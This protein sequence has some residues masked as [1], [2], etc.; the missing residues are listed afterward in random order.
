MNRPSIAF[1]NWFNVTFSTVNLHCIYPT[2]QP[3]MAI[4]TPKYRL[5]S[6]LCSEVSEKGQRLRSKVQYVLQEQSVLDS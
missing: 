2:S 6:Y 1:S 4:M 3:G 5:A